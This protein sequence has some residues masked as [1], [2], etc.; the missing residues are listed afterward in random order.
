MADPTTDEGEAAYE[1]MLA[2]L[3]ARVNDP[4]NCQHEQFAASVAVARLL[5]TGRFIAEVRVVCVTCREPMRF[6]GLEPGLR[7]CEPSCSIDGTVANLPV[8]PEI[9]KR[10][11]GGARYE[12][13]PKPETRQ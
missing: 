6:L 5:D 7:W 10:L 3:P 12:M 1:R 4:K 8:E 13:P 2:N 9:E 11:F